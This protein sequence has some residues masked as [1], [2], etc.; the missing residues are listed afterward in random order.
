[1]QNLLR[2]FMKMN[3]FIVLVVVCLL[4]ACGEPLTDEMVKAVG[5]SCKNQNK[6][7]FINRTFN[8]AKCQ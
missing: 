4:T 6:V 3:K 5:E 7:L 2:C 8:I 1:M